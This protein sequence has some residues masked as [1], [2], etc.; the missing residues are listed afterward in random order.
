[1]TGPMNF[2]TSRAKA[3]D[4][5]PRHLKSEVVH[6]RYSL[7]N[8][9]WNPVMLSLSVTRVNEY[10]G[11]REMNTLI[12]EQLS[13]HLINKEERRLFEYQLSFLQLVV[14]KNVVYLSFKHRINKWLVCFG[15]GKQ[16]EH[17]V[18]HRISCINCVNEFIRIVNILVSIDRHWK[19]TILD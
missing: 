12:T 8:V 4:K 14:K 15:I 1:M 5:L 13:Q 18:Y 6:S 9:N 17:S 3:N 19:H 2:T 16:V 7:V 10:H 11:S